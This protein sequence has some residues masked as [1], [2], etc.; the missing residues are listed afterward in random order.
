MILERFINVL[1]ECFVGWKQAYRTDEDG[2]T[3]DMNS[4]PRSMCAALVKSLKTKC[5]VQF[6]GATGSY[7]FFNTNDGQFYNL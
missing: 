6:N 3:G 2:R 5:K 7:Y 1:T 4:L